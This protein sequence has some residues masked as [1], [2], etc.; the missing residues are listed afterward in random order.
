MRTR[1]LKRSAAEAALDSDGGGDDDEWPDEE[2][3]LVVELRA[4]SSTVK[5]DATGG[6]G[7]TLAQA[8]AFE[9]RALLPA[10]T[11]G[12]LSFS[13]NL[14]GGCPKRDAF[15]VRRLG[16]QAIL[17]VVDQLHTGRTLHGLTPA[18]LRCAAVE[19]L[20]STFFGATASAADETPPDSDA[21]TSYAVKLRAAD[22]LQLVLKAQGSPGSYQKLQITQEDWGDSKPA[23]EEA[24]FAPQLSLSEQRA[25]RCARELL[26]LRQID[27]QVELVRTWTCFAAICRCVG[28][29][30]CRVAAQGGRT[31]VDWLY[32]LLS[33]LAI[34]PAPADFSTIEI[35]SA[36]KID[37]R[38]QEIVVAQL[39]SAE[40]ALVQM[41]PSICA[42][43][44][45]GTH[46]QALFLIRCS[47]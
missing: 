18:A 32:L 47:G 15:A 1:R 6:F 25:E 22:C 8:A 39:F 19:L 36:R 4:E 43:A 42:A 3:Q 26:L 17:D 41:P 24:S 21:E 46:S 12:P 20:D 29:S 5:G 38:G 23:G 2:H 9:R 35:V 11:S 13:A 10:R 7:C 31:A 45:L 27:W 16:V 44:A 34:V 14:L 28:E 30:A 40:L 37:R 33:H